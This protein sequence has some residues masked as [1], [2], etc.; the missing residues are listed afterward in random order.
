[1]SFDVQKQGFAQSI[2]T[3]INMAVDPIQCMR[4]IGL[5]RPSARLFTTGPKRYRSLTVLYLAG[6]EHVR[7]VFSAPDIFHTSNPPM[8]YPGGGAP[9]RLRRGLIGNQGAEHTHYRAS[10]TAQTGRAM[11]QEF[12]VAVAT[13]ADAFLRKMREDEPV[14]IVAMINDLVRYYAVVTMFK[15]D[16]PE[17]ALQVGRH[18]TAWIDLAYDARNILAPLNIPGLPHARFR[19]AAN[20]L[21]AEILEWAAQR[22][23]M[24]AKRD[25]L[26]MF[27][28]GPDENGQPLPDDRLTGH[29][30]TL[31]ASSFS[32][33]VASLIW[34]LFLLMQHPDI[35]HD[36]CDELDAS[37]IDPLTDPMKLLELP[38]LDRVLKECMRLFTPVPYQVRRVAQPIQVGNVMLQESNKVLIGSWATNRMAST[39]TDAER[40]K[41]DR[42]LTEEIGPFD[43]LTFSAGPRRCVGYGLAM[44]IVKVTLATILLKRRPHLL[45]N[46]RIDTRVAITLRSK[47]PIPVVMAGRNARMVRAAVHGTVSNLY[48][49]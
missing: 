19:R 46:T 45:E 38:L 16:N 25:L 9:A 12:S 44:V 7:P 18:I 31:Y 37:G 40:F 49:A 1:M 2:T 30:M 24:D 42:W 10:F 39:Y 6:G 13:H 4:A 21:E 17:F 20:A 33:S 27:V 34:S 15:D 35:A 11:M 23:G 41:P 29:I 22:R 26:S 5:D 28:N 14:D 43:Y 36:L 3:M 8:R 48:A 32:S 47:Q